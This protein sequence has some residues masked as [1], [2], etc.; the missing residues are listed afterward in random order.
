MDGSQNVNLTILDFQNVAKN[1]FWPLFLPS[2]KY[3]TKNVDKYS[4]NWS[5]FR[6]ETNKNLFQLRKKIVIKLTDKISMT[7]CLL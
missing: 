5:L 2:N 6:N 4:E 3:F 7:K 1:I